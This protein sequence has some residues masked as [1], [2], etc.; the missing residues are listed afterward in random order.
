MPAIRK[1]E[2]CLLS[3]ELLRRLRLNVLTTPHVHLPGSPELLAVVRPLAGKTLISIIKK[4]SD[5][6]LD[7]EAF[8]SRALG[9][10]VRAG[11]QYLGYKNRA[12]IRRHLRGIWERS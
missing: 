9:N 10:G 11:E 7:G 5:R 1:A 2:E 8:V 3:D 6:P 12:E 4:V